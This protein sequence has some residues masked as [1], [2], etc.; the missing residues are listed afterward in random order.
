M[1]ARVKYLVG[2]GD[3][4]LLVA[5]SSYGEQ[6]PDDEDVAEENDRERDDGDRYQRDP[7][8]YERLVVSV[9]R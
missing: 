2:G 9:P 3:D 7:R 6:C 4:G 5:E 8:P 1:C